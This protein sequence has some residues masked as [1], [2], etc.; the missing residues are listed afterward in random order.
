MELNVIYFKDSR[1]MKEIDDQSITLV[2]TSPPYWNV[3]NYA[4]DGYQQEERH[5]GIEGQIGDLQD[6]KQYLNALNVVWQECER[7]LKPNGKLCVNA[8]VMP[9]PK[10]VINTD[11]TRY[12]VNIYSD[13]ER[14][15]LINTKLKLMDVYIWER[16]NPTKRLM[17]GSYPFPPNFYAQN[18]SEF[19]GVFVKDGEPEK[20]PME[21]KE[22]SKLTE[23]E[24][25]NYT[26]QV[27]RISIPNTGD[28]A[29]GSHPAIMPLELAERLIRLYSFVEDIVLDPFMGSG[30]TAKAARNLKRHY[31]GYEIDPS[32]KDVIARKLAEQLLLFRS[33]PDGPEVAYGE[34]LK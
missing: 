23:E 28:E 17:F 1:Q 4:L 26:K 18:T 21:I 31:I 10:K 19:I 7:V 29:Y 9:I 5:A 22:A 6:Y 27:W 15:I 34:F 3:K 33:K 16:A 32:Y 25:V 20:K 13:I 12:I 2:V 24:W 14:E 30:T 8:P 11:Y